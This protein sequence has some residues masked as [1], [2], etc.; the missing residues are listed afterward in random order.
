MAFL[1][2]LLAHVAVGNFRV[3]GRSMI[4]T[5]HNNEFIL[6]DKISYDVTSPHRGDI[7]VFRYPLNPSKDF[8][9]RIIGVPGDRVAIHN[10]AVFVNGRRLSE[11]YIA[12]EPDYSMHSI[13][14]ASGDVVPKGEYFVLGD[15]RNNSDDSHLWGPVPRKN[16]IGRALLS[17]WPPQ[18]FNI[19][20]DPS[21]SRTR[22]AA[23]R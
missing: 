18:D 7:V 14:G 9:K 15:N 22:A 8:V 4:P 12:Q 6:V 11:D 16:I 17:Y 21:T 5:L 1:L 13:L 19:F 20:T 3:D 10:H 23:A 2:F